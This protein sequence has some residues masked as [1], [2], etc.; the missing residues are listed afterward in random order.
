MFKDTSSLPIYYYL[1]IRFLK[2]DYRIINFV[3]RIIS[4]IADI[5]CTRTYTRTTC[6][7]RV[8]HGVSVLHVK[9]M[10][11]ML[12]DVQQNK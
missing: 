7:Q 4:L 11:E 10:M 5:K 1:K 9:I 2:K 12:L 8:A 3:K 6:T